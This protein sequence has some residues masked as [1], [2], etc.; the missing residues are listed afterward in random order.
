MATSSV[1]F[2]RQRQL[3]GFIPDVVVEE[4]HIDDLE[5]T[6]HPVERGA[7]ISDHAYKRPPEL[8]MDMILRVNGGGFFGAL[9]SV[10]DAA[11][12]PIGA[13]GQ[14]DI[15]PTGVDFTNTS[16][17]PDDI[18]KA[19]IEKQESR[20]LFDVITGKREYVNMLLR[21]VQVVTNDESENVLRVTCRMQSIIIV[22]TQIVDISGIDTGNTPVYGNN[23]TRKAKAQLKKIRD[24][25]GPGVG[26]YGR[27]L[28]GGGVTQVPG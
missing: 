25:N 22:E 7:N 24:T 6:Q 17:N 8:E 12:D 13:I 5:I 20:E 23:K 27:P 19:L 15:K 26:V 14:V 21:Q 18:Y 16:S 10:L 9:G 4:R 3:A 28:P 2:F 11:A 1:T